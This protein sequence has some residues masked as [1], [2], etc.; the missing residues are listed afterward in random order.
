MVAEEIDMSLQA[1]D[2]HLKEADKALRDEVFWDCVYH[3]ASAAENAANA[4][5]LR[6]GGKPPHT[7][8]DAKAIKRIASRERPE[9]L[10][11]DDFKLAVEKMAGLE[12][13]VVRT[14]Y[15]IEVEP[16]KFLPPHEYYKRKD[17]ER[18]LEDARFVVGVIKRLII[19]KWGE[20]RK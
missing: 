7:H 16:K 19:R 1:A 13:H 12:Q 4:L 9:W 5:I 17:A 2:H 8:E 15:P 3:S 6:L 14:R 18:A 10:Q 11:K 20:L